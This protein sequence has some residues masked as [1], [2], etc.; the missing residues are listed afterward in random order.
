MLHIND[1]TYHIEGRVLFD[2]ATAAIS[3]GWK[4]GFV[5]ANGTGKS[6]LFALL[7]GELTPEAGS[8]SVPENWVVAHMA[9]EFTDLDKP[10]IEFVLDGDRE[11]RAAQR[12]IA[13]AEALRQ[14]GGLGAARPGAAYSAASEPG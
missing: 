3:D 11:L 13:A 12:A 10:A 14:L 5:G 2:Q 9:Q 1:L 8:L 6:S 4:V 7:R